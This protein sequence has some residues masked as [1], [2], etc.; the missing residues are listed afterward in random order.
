MVDGGS[1]V[2]SYTEW[3]PL[4]EVIVGHVHDAMLPS[5]NRINRITFPPGVWSAAELAGGGGIPYPAARIEAA[6]QDLAEFI[7]VLAAAGVRVRRPEPS[8]FS[9]GYG[10]PDWRVENGFCAANPRD[11]LLV[12]GDEL[13]EVP[14]ADRGRYFETWPYRSLLREYF[15]AGARW[16]AAPKPQSRPEPDSSARRPPWQQRRTP[17]RS[18]TR[19]GLASLREGPVA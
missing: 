7:G 13:I 15:A 17:L 16:T 8:R 12:V 9:A 4:E 5:W 19:E 10:T 1:P 14:M 11:V 2:L 18:R 3:D 6:E